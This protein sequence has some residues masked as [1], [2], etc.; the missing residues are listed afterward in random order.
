MSEVAIINDIGNRTEKKGRKLYREN[1]HFQRLA[2]IMEHPEFRTFFE[3]YMQDWESAKTIIMFMKIYEA[4]EKHS[5][6]QLT[7]YQK[8]AVVKDV[9][10]DRELRSK[11]CAGIS[12]DCESIS[13]LGDTRRNYIESNT[14]STD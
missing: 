5:K 3:E 2:H 11:I 9:I 6:V 14:P 12:K 7:P 4:V 8:I 10:D 1:Q 13:S